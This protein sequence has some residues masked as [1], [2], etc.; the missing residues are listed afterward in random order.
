M[1]QT[2]Y[3]IA[4]VAHIVGITIMAGTT[5]IDFISFK[6][7]WKT[8]SNNRSAALVIAD[9]LYKLQRFMGIGMLI[10]IVSGVNMM[11]FLHQVWGEQ[12][13]FR[14]KIGILVLVIINGLAL[15][16]RLGNS[17]KKL[18]DELPGNE[19]D[20]KLVKLKGNITISHLFQFLFFVTI[21]IL[22]VFKFN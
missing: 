15:R 3:K 16:R 9:Y 1:E 10:I 22:S 4:L 20:S 7:F 18:L 6:Q 5:F 13:W 21:F 19:M 17:L 11:I 2:I 8:L 14:V 12:I